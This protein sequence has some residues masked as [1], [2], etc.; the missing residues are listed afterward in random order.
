VSSWFRRKVDTRIR[1]AAGCRLSSLALDL[2]PDGFLVGVHPGPLVVFLGRETAPFLVG[3]V[4]ERPHLLDNVSAIQAN[5]PALPASVTALRTAAPIWNGYW[6]FVTAEQ[7]GIW[8]YQ[9]FVF[10]PRVGMALRINDRTA[11]RVG[12]ARFVAPSEYNFVLG[13]NLYSGLGSISF[14]EAPFM[15][16]DGLSNPLPLANGIPQQTISN[17]FPSANPLIVPKGKSYG[18]YYGLGEGNV[19][20]ANSDFKRQVNDR[21]NVS[22][23]RQIWNQIVA[24]VTYFV[25][26][27]RDWS[28]FPRDLNAWDPRIGY[29]LP[30]A[31]KSTMDAAVANPFYNYLTAEKFPG[32]LRNQKTVPTKNLL[33]PYPQ[34][35]GLWQIFQS[36]Q[37]ERYH[38]LQV[39]V[40]RPFRN[41]YNFLFG[42]NYRR[43][44]VQGYYD[45]LGQ[46][47]GQL[48][49]LQA[50]NSQTMNSGFANPR[51]SASIAGAYELP[52]G[53]GHRLGASAPKALD[54]AFGGWHIIGA[55]YFNSGDI[56]VFGPLAATGDPHLDNPTPAKWFDTSK[57]SR[58]PAYTQRTNPRTYDDVRGPMTW[59]I[60]ALVGKTFSVGDKYKTHLRMTAYNLTNRLNRAD[61]I[62]DITLSTFGTANRQGATV[63]RQLEFGLKVIF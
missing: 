37:S 6:K 57:L 22:F 51:H 61:P 58:L 14:L 26:I 36:N 40:Q 53:K 2:L 28:M 48:S 25:N 47:L 35:G 18:Q 24:G 9:K 45:E 15:G 59:D 23:S 46:F 21:I 60:Q 63:G 34:Y 17:P 41:G 33:R 4:H 8:N 1:F 20:W 42:Y 5:P 3:L 27:G 38:S 44:K 10:M 52:F 43:E 19:G 13:G 62:T 29:N 32:P 7:R 16:L 56:I 55:W 50:G 49:W 31:S 39:K 12:W 54:F 30:T 11:L